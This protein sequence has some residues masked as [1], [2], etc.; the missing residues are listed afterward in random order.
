ME[1]QEV[2]ERLRQW[3][4]AHPQAPFD[5]IDAEGQR[6]FAPL[7]AQVVAEL[8]AQALSSFARLADAETFGRQ[9]LCELH[10]RG[11]AA[12]AVIYLAGCYAVLPLEE[13]LAVLG[14]PVREGLLP[15]LPPTRSPP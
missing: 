11:L 1:E 4:A 7:H 15:V 3:R 2:W 12:P 5:A 14:V 8:S 13:L 9:P 10:R 6:Q